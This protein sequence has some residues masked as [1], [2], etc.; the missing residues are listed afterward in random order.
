MKASIPATIIP[1][2]CSCAE[3]IQLLKKIGAWQEDDRYIPEPGDII[4]Y[5]WDDAATGYAT[6]DNAGAPEH[7]G[8][9]ECVAGGQITVIEGNKGKAVGRRMVSVNGRFIRGYGVPK[10]PDDTTKQ[11]DDTV[12]QDQFEA[13]YKTMTDKWDNL[14]VADNRAPEDFEAAKAAGLTDGSRPQSLATRQEVAVMAYRAYKT[15][16]AGVQAAAEK[17]LR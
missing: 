11:E 7:V 10:Y 3:M 4:F 17:A 12:T 16:L 9:V 13:M 8:I 5:D 1:R 6:T 15:T 2:E 14:G